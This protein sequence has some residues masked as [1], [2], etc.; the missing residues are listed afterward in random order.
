MAKNADNITL[1]LGDLTVNGADAGYLGGKVVFS[2]DMDLQDWDA[3]V[4]VTVRD[5]SIK[6]FKA[7]LK[8]SLAQLDMDTLRLSLGVGTVGNNGT[9]LNLGA[10]WILP[11]LNN[12]RFVHTRDDGRTMSVFFHKAKIEPNDFALVFTPND[13][14]YQD[15]VITSIY[16]GTHAENPLGYIDII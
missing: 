8:A 15:V 11:T 16:D 6:G 13:F 2:A 1:G 10:S 5:R 4:P 14:I 9:R 3:G 12:V 7:S